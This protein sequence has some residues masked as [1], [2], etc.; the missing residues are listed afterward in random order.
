MNGQIVLKTLSSLP[1]QDLIMVF[2]LILNQIVYEQSLIT[3]RFFIYHQQLEAK[4]TTNLA[5]ITRTGIIR[6]EVEI[7]TQMPQMESLTFST[8]SL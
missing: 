3:D 6:L 1:N 5:T 2:L 4:I 7:A 8:Q